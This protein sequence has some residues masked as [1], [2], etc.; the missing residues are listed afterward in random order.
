ME[1]EL[2]KFNLLYCYI[3]FFFSKLNTFLII[4]LFFKIII[5]IHDFYIFQEKKG[6]MANK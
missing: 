4:I 6:S 5:K 2:F 1:V 3:F